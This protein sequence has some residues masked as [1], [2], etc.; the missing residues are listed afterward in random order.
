MIRV[1]MESSDSSL[2]ILI[3]Q[4][5]SFCCRS[6]IRPRRFRGLYKREQSPAIAR[7]SVVAAEHSNVPWSSSG[8]RSYA[9]CVGLWGRQAPLDRGIQVGLRARAGAMVAFNRANANR[10]SPGADNDEA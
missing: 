1:R 3:R 9:R 8:E 10:A 2:A 6:L 7:S 5:G 4:R